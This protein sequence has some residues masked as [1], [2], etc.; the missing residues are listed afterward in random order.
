MRLPTKRDAERF[1]SKVDKTPGHGPNGD[2]WVW[3]AGLHTC[4]YGAF[5]MAGSY[6]RAHRVAFRLCIGNPSPG[7][8]VMH[9]CDVR[10]CC[11]PAHLRLGTAA[12][13]VRDAYA[14]GRIRRTARTVP[15]LDAELLQLKYEYDHGLS[16]QTLSKKWH[17][18]PITITRLLDRAELAAAR[19]TSSAPPDE[20]TTR[21]ETSDP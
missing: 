19:A 20:N 6:C 18:P 7:L 16:K 21:Q 8:F 9:T 15:L 1:W 11:N 2:C 12:D 17:L 3:T 14:K 4:G 5:S 13:N 10:R